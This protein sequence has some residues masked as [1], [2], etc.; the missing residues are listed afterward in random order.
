MDTLAA[1]QV[2]GSLLS[3]LELLRTTG[4]LDLSSGPKLTRDL[5]FPSGVLVADSPTNT[6]RLLQL[7]EYQLRSLGWQ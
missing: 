5:R 1:N 7:M 4:V 6:W 3:L 2:D